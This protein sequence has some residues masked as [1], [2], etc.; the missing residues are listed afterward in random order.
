MVKLDVFENNP[1]II[2]RHYV[3][4]WCS[5]FKT[6]MSSW[7]PQHSYPL[8][9]NGGFT[10]QKL[11]E[12]DS[13]Q[14]IVSRDHFYDPNFLFKQWSWADLFPINPYM[15]YLLWP[16]FVSNI[17]KG[18][19]GRALNWIGGAFLQVPYEYLYFMSYCK[20]AK[21]PEKSRSIMVHSGEKQLINVYVHIMGKIMKRVSCKILMIKDMYGDLLQRGH[22]PNHECYSSALFIH[23]GLH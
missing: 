15:P 2:C 4:F 14:G 16:H 3:R 18:E 19:G 10:T 9:Y 13:V 8:P 7:S 20:K 22:W 1:L 23:Q 12:V 5:K 6:K 17:N 21:G 11:L